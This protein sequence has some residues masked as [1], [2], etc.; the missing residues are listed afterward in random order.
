MSLSTH[1]HFNRLPK[2]VKL[3]IISSIIPH[4]GIINSS[5]EIIFTACTFQNNTVPK[6]ECKTLI[7]SGN[8]LSSRSQLNTQ[9]RKR[10]DKIAFGYPL[11][12]TLRHL[13]IFECELNK[14]SIKMVEECIL[15]QMNQGLPILKATTVPLDPTFK[16]KTN[17]SLRASSLALLRN[18]QIMNIPGLQD[19]IKSYRFGPG[20]G[21]GYKKRKTKRRRK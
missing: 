8:A 5:D 4:K 10:V 19:M 7:F 3:F 21:S 16:Q 20:H 12:L 13:R 14:K 11:P 6:F 18:K 1:V 17:V 9:K 15:H 2:S